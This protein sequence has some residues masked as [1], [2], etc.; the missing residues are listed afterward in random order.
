MRLHSRRRALLLRLS[1]SP[2]IVSNLMYPMIEDNRADQV[3]LNVHNVV[4]IKRTHHLDGGINHRTRRSSGSGSS[5]KKKTQKSQ[6]E[7]LNK[8]NFLI[9]S[10]V[11]QA[12]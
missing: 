5:S 11:M 3:L 7:Y 1:L 2:R 9:L 8:M 4:A 6:G 12:Q 10:I